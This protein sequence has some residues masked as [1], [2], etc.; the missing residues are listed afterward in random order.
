MRI[1]DCRIA[2]VFAAVCLLTSWGAAQPAG[3]SLKDTLEAL[4]LEDQV[5]YL[6]S[7]LTE[8]GGKADVSFYLGNAYLGLENPDSA[9]VYFAKTV[10][11]DSMYAKAYV[12]M[13]IALEQLDRFEEAKR[14]YLL[15][16]ERNPNDVLAHCHL[17]H[18]YY[19]RGQIAEAV[20][21]YRRALLIDPNSAQAHYNLGL[22]FADSRLFA[23][24]VREWD[25]V[26]ELSPDSELGRTAAENVALIRTYLEV[27]GSKKGD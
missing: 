14:S 9:V 17:G 23:E 4:P 7:L 25:R 6:K 10:A 5:P 2:V 8:G 18:Y 16:I 15:A 11:I 12:N 19:V 27:G 20:D 22:A 13:A 26:V 21:Y 3:S 24:A 1:L